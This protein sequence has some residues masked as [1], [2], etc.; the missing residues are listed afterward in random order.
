MTADEY[1]EVRVE[2][3]V[4]WYDAKS[5]ANQRWFKWLRLA[6]IS[7]AATIPL[8]SAFVSQP[9]VPLAVGV[10]GALVAVIAGALG[11]FQFER[12]WVKYRTAGQSLQKEKFLFQTKTAP[13]DRDPEQNYAL[14]VQRVETLVSG[15]NTDW[16]RVMLRP[17]EET[18]G[19]SK[20]Q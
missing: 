17:G 5:M 20:A 4:L 8:L 6:E 2:N 13:F 12:N 7:A 9:H 19:P 3:Q 1:M 11:H 16:A 14:L 10:L 15:E 18:S